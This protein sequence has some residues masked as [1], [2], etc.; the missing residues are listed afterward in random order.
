MESPEPLSQTALVHC[1]ATI[2]CHEVDFEALERTQD[3]ALYGRNRDAGQSF[4]DLLVGDLQC[5]L[6]EVWRPDHQRVP[7]DIL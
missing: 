4:L 3:H 5:S 6:I 1:Q 7:V 2:G